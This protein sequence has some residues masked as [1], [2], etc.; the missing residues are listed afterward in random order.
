MI[1]MNVELDGIF[2]ENNSFNFSYDDYVYEKENEDPQSSG[3]KAVLIPLLYSVVL[4]AGLLGN[5]LLIAVLS[6]KKRAWSLSDIFI[7]LLSVSDILL[8]VTLPFWS[9]Q[10]TQDCGWCFGVP[11]CKISG[12]VFNMNF[13]C[14]IF[15]LVCIS[16]NH[17]LFIAHS[18]L[19]Y[20][21]NRPKLAY[22]S[23][24]LVWFVSFLLTIPDWDFLVV[25]RTWKENTVCIPNC[26]LPQKKLVSRL[27]H[28]ILGFLLPAV[29]LIICCSCILLSKRLQKQRA[30]ILA[31]VV[32]FLSCWTPYNITLIVDTFKN[33]SKTP[34]E[35]ANS[36]GSLKTALLVTSS[37][38]CVHACLRPVLYFSL[39][40]NFRERMLALLRCSKDE[41]EDSL[42]ELGVGEKDLP[43]K[44][45]EGEALK[46]ITIEE[47]QVQTTK[48]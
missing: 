11:L 7:L 35:I 3:S 30:I 2:N 45:H 9:A 4:I 15:L 13:Y 38:A 5:G 31:L 28:H 41:C 21:H 39:C 46:Q 33:S 43:A 48:C 10:A 25:E 36:E 20:S 37:L 1:N 26:Y 17:Y 40:R 18:T 44:T 6:Q 47:Q 19:L 34:Q 16:L 27:F 29:A 14:G 12:A 32:V 24:L 8:L 42:W 23:F 22:I